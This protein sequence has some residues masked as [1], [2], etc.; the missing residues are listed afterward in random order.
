MW[1]IFLD[2]LCLIICDIDICFI[3]K[4]LFVIQLLVSSEF[5]IKNIYLFSFLKFISIWLILKLV[6]LFVCFFFFF[7][8]VMIKSDKQVDTTD[9]FN[10]WIVLGL[11]NPGPFNKYV[12]LRLTHIVEY[13]WVDTTRTR[14]ANTNCH[15]NTSSMKSK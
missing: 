4:L 9:P 13:S 11:T 6:C 12:W 7:F 15:H 14:H 5:Y 2:I 10:K 8:V 3:F 1:F